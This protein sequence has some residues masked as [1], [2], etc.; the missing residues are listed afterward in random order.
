MTFD[1]MRQM[2]RMLGLR[3]LLINR[4]R[5]EGRRKGYRM[6]QRRKE[7]YK[8]GGEQQMT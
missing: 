6:L 3:I 1:Y 5:E 2:S 4:M 7:E 8:K